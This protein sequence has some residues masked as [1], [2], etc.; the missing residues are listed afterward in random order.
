MLVSLLVR[1]LV[2]AAIIVLAAR[3]PPNRSL[4]NSQPRKLARP[5]T[6]HRAPQ[7]RSKHP[8]RMTALALQARRTGSGSITHLCVASSSLQTRS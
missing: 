4:R 8:V 6:R 2:P 3:R 1:A 7:Q 5:A